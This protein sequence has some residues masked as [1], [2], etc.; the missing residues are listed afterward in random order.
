MLNILGIL[1]IA[2]HNVAAHVLSH[3]H[4]EERAHSAALVVACR[5][6]TFGDVLSHVSL[7]ICAV[8]QEAYGSAHSRALVDNLL[9]FVAV[10][11]HTH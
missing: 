5:V 6:D 2:A 7:L 9:A 10:G 11:R 1:H 3:A 4:A 8:A